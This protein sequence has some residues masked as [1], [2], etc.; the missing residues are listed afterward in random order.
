MKKIILYFI[1]IFI[2]GC[3]NYEYLKSNNTA[4]RIIIK[5]KKSNRIFTCIQN[6]QDIPTY[7]S[8]PAC[9]YWN[10]EGDV[11]ATGIFESIRIIK[12]L[13]SFELPKNDTIELIK[14]GKWHYFNPEGL[15][16]SIV[17]YKGIRGFYWKVDTFDLDDQYIAI[18]SVLQINYKKTVLYKR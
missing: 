9:Y 18:D 14:Y 4:K 5:Q 1:P 7:S 2:L 10:D 16:D 13:D 3:S 12:K 15:L 17:D 11:K 6:E 8:G